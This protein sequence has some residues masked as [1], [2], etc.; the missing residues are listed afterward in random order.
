MLRTKGAT[1][2]LESN[3]ILFNH[4]PH[5]RI[6]DAN[7]VRKDCREYLPNWYGAFIDLDD[8]QAHA[9]VHIVAPRDWSMTPAAD[10]CFYGLIEYYDQA[11]PSDCIKGRDLFHEPGAVTY[12]DKVLIHGDVRKRHRGYWLSHPL[13][14]YQGL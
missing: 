2:N 4:H 5:A 13:E 10:H 14:N 7:W 1:I 8:L 6:I 11:T 3:V 12:G 9:T